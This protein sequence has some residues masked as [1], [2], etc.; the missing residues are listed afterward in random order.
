MKTEFSRLIL[1]VDDIDRMSDFYGGVL[2]LDKLDGGD[3]GFV[4]FSAGAGQVCLHSLP[5]QYR[6]SSEEYPKRE[7]THVKFVFSSDDI[8]RDRQFLLEKGIRMGDKVRY[9]LVEFCDGADPE[10]NIF[11]ISSRE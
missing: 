10:G 9:G 2:G 3:S 6:T 1:F 11:Q 8:E 5:P 4:C 7:D